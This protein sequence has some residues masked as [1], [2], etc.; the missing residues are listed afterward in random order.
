MIVYAVFQEGVYR[1]DC[2]GIFSTINIA[3]EEARKAILTEDD[4]YHHFNICSFELDNSS[5]EKLELTFN[6]YTSGKKIK[7]LATTNDSNWENCKDRHNH[8]PLRWNSS[9]DVNTFYTCKDC[10]VTNYVEVI[11]S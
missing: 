5:V 7:V 3:R 8:F 2:V 4:D 9:I 10:G 11:V 6:R 1:H